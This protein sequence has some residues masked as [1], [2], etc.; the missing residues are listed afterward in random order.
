V[1][2]GKTGTEFRDFIPARSS[3]PAM[4][5]QQRAI[6]VP[7]GIV[8][9]AARDRFAPRKMRSFERAF[10]SAATRLAAC[11]SRRC[12]RGTTIASR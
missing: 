8:E 12:V 7:G 10:I 3:A 5:I 11:Y 4:R 9:D 2:Q 6:V 1:D